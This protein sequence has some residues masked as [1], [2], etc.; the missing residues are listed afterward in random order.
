[1]VHRLKQAAPLSRILG[2]TATIVATVLGLTP[3]TTVAAPAAASV[4]S[5]GAEPLIGGPTVDEELARQ[6][7]LNAWLLGEMPAGTLASPISLRLTPDEQSDLARK[8]KDNP[9]GPAVVGRAKAL[10]LV[11]R[12]TGLDA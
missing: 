3:S 6:G 10:G 8:Q 7:Q 4:E 1:M 11:V 2:L 5:I 9:N 12:F